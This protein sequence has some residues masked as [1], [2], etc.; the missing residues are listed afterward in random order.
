MKGTDI[1]EFQPAQ[2]I[3]L[4]RSANTKDGMM[5]NTTQAKSQEGISF[6]ADGH[7]AVLNKANKKLRRN[8]T[9]N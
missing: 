9:M 8:R 1:T 2:D 4:E 5:Y 6:P 3:K 7:Q